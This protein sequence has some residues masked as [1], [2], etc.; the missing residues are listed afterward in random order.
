MHYVR[1]SLA[2][3]GLHV[4]PEAEDE[5]VT[6]GGWQRSGTFQAQHMRTV[7]NVTHRGSCN[8]A[9]RYCLS[10]DVAGSGL[11]ARVKNHGGVILNES[12]RNP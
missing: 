5:V 2:F 7:D 4:I 12:K 10:E 8:I 6:L 3:Q 1:A 9:R 11:K